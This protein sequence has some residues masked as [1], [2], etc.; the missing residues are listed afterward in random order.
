MHVFVDNWSCSCGEMKTICTYYFKSL[1]N[2]SVVDKTEYTKNNIKEHSFVMVVLFD[3]AKQQALSVW[4]APMESP[5][6]RQRW[7]LVNM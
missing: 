7:L 6:C 1:E 4:P 3:I 2:M 5:A